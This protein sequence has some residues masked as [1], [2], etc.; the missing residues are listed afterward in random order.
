[1]QSCGCKADYSALMPEKTLGE[2]MRDHGGVW[3]L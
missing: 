3:S 2:I 1:M